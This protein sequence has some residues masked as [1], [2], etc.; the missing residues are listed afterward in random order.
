MTALRW[1]GFPGG[2]AVSWLVGLVILAAALAVPGL[3][4]SQAVV[5]PGTSA[6]VG[7]GS[8]GGVVVDE[9]KALEISQAVL[10][11]VPADVVLRDT[12]GRE[13]RL[14]DFRGKPVLLSLIY[15]SC[16]HTCPMITQNLIRAV[17]VADGAVGA[18]RY[19]VITLGF[20][21]VA[22]TPERMVAFG[23]SQGIDRS[24]WSLLSG[25]SATIK[26][27][28]ADLGFSFAPSPKGFDHLAQVTMLDR[29]GRIVRQIYGEEF[30]AQALVEPLKQLLSGGS[31]DLAG[32]LA[33]LLDRVRLLCTVYDPTQGRYRF[34][35]SLF[36]GYFVGV[37]CF[38]VAGA[39]LVREWRKAGPRVS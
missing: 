16:Y 6:V 17:N 8:G 29:D 19:D 36:I 27:L 14:S 28:S 7:D 37:A 2:G 26:T 5:P 21:A 12:A 25:D 39:V 9:R 10:G 33:G 18:K 4:W 38:S 35:I 3:A 32:G 15:T 34:S 20:D 13:V 30:P 31:L 1:P 24:G 22:D 11:R 23:R